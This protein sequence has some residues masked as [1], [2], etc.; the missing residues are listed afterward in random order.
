MINM[1]LLELLKSRAKSNDP[2]KVGL[3]G[4]GKFGIMFL[5][6]AL[7]LPG[8]HLLGIADLSIE[9]VRKEIANTGWSREKFSARSLKDAIKSYKTYITEDAEELINKDSLDVLIEA[10][11]DPSVGI[12]HALKAIE[13]RINVVMVNVEADALAG[14]LLAKKAKSKDC[15]YSLA[16]GDQPA[17][18]C[19][20]IEWAKITGFK[21]VCA[22][23]GTKYLSIYRTSTPDI[24]WEYYGFSKERAEQMNYNPK[25][26]NSFLDGTKSAI[27]MAAVSNASGLHPQPDGL[28]FPPASINEL[29]EVCKPKN[30]GGQLTHKGTVEVVSSLKRDGKL[31]SQDLRWGVYII[32]EAPNEYVKNCFSDYGLIT[33]TSG[34]YA[35]MYRPNHLIGLELAV[36]I[37]RVGLRGEATGSPGRFC[38]DVVTV[39]KRDLNKGEMLDGEGGYLVFGILLPAKKSLELNL[40]PI[41]LA[42]GMRLKK[43]IKKD[44]FIHWTD[45][46]YD[47]NDF[48][49]KFRREMEKIF[50]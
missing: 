27:E 47:K 37:L 32:I 22:G 44:K 49:F 10:T 41:G 18:I 36:S 40:L 1:E 50:I 30:E 45:I 3:I 38:A 29:P 23:K 42:S 25:M 8:L 34:N 24:V 48:I 43:N 6:Q 31:I 33:D 21:V 19:E 9:K 14:A 17:I 11:G 7:R 2:L 12:K 28:Q 39:S 46:E 26:F 16:Y 35:A 5:N 20:M 13:R 4:A 15:V